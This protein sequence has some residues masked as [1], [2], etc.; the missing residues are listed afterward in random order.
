[1]APPCAPRCRS[2]PRH[3]AS[4]AGPAGPAR[5]GRLRQPIRARG[6]PTGP[7]RSSRS[8][9]CRSRCAATCCS[10]R[11]RSTT[12]TGDPAGRY[13]RRTHVADRG[14]GGSAAPA[15]RPSARDA[16][17]RHRQPD[18]D[19]GRQAAER[20]RARRHA[21][22]GGQRHRRP[23]RH[24]RRWPAV[25]RMGCWAPTSCWR[26]TSISTCRRSASRSTAPGASAPTPRRRGTSPTVAV[27]GRQHAARPSAGAVRARRGGRHGRAGYRRAVQLDQPEHGGA[28]RSG[29]GRDGDGPHGDGAWR[30][31]RSGGGAHP[32][33]PRVPRRSRDDAHAGAAGGAEGRRHGRCAGGRRLPA[34][35]AGVAVVLDAADVRDA[36]GNAGRGSR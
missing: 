21:L 31:T 13:R 10:C 17:L 8:P 26:S 15:A 34:G 3:D 27:V 23:L 6:A 28:D 35:Q 11:R 24:R 1:M 33:L 32:S 19:L 22:P 16:H 4:D 7:A 9:R 5:H 25:R 36:A 30:G 20:H 12:R 18:R 14:R 2:A 29:G